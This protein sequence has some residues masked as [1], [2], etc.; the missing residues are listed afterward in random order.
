[1]SLILQCFIIF[2]SSVLI[3]NCNRGGDDQIDLETDDNK[4]DDNK[5]ENNK[6]DDNKTENNNSI[7]TSYAQKTNPQIDAKIL[8]AGRSANYDLIKKWI[9]SKSLTKSQV[10]EL[11]R[12]SV[13]T[14]AQNQ[15]DNMDD[16][17]ISNKAK[18]LDLLLQNGG[19]VNSI[20][21]NNKS[22]LMKAV[23]CP[24]KIIETILKYKPDINYKKENGDTAL[25]LLIDKGYWVKLDKVKLLVKAGADVNTISNNKSILDYLSVGKNESGS[26][27]TQIYNYLVKNGA[28][29]KNPDI[30]RI[31]NLGDSKKLNN[32]SLKKS[33]RGTILRLTAEALKKDKS[34]GNNL[35]MLKK[36]IE[37]GADINL[38]LYESIIENNPDAF[39]YLI[40]QG[41]DYKKIPDNITPIEQ[42]LFSFLDR[43][44]YKGEIYDVLSK[45]GIKSKYPVRAAVMRKDLN[46]IKNYIRDHPNFDINN[47]KDEIKEYFRKGDPI[48]KCGD[49]SILNYLLDN[50][51]T[52]FSIE[53][54]YYA[55]SYYLINK[56]LPLIKFLI[57]KKLVDINGEIK[58]NNT[59]A[60][61]IH[62]FFEER[63]KLGNLH[64][65]K[66]EKDILD[67]LISQGWDYKKLDKEGKNILHILADLY[68]EDAFLIDYFL[69]KKDL[70]INLKDKTN[71]TPLD[72]AKTGSYI[73][74]IFVKKGAEHSKDL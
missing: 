28:K 37:I 3:T 41:A 57:N 11:L 30:Y 34:T 2:L 71:R 44:P 47:K 67:Y 25:K 18:I 8:N 68:S 49:V 52:K 43:V 66:D 33:D 55:F 70:P 40:S 27:L 12:M 64:W 56:N 7:D 6:T 19:D 45:L 31:I 1:M 58:I 50:L 59:Y 32:K 17:Y 16:G 54:K 65:T 38:C 4:T 53:D 36:L 10:K 5:T 74:S 26:E 62:K 51:K 15:D 48:L 61:F 69:K 14:M 9:E 22:L 20:F 46:E 39:K 29:H 73:Y 35:T 72:L 21:K 24:S 60:T 63:Y 13:F 23:N 42:T